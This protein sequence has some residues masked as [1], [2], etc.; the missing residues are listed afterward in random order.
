VTSSRRRRELARARYER[1]V[2]RREAQ[3]QRARRRQAVIGSVL[4]VALVIGGVFAL[5]S[6]LRDGDT[7]TPAADAPDPSPAATTSAP[8]QQP[9]RYTASGTPARDVGV[10]RFDAKAAAEPYTATIRTNRGPVTLE[11]RSADAPCA[12][13][14][15]RYLAEK[16]FFDKTPCPRLAN[17]G[18]LAILQCG[19]PTGT[20]TGGPGYAFP[21]EN[22]E[23]ATYPAGTV[24]MAN[25]G[26]N[27]NGSQFFLVF[28]DSQLGPSYTPFGTITGGLDVLTTVAA[29]GDDGSNPAGGGK[30]KAP[31]TIEQ[32]TVAV[33]R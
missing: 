2:A 33:R 12:A 23:G 13:Y 20:T 11:A 26:P 18:T 8:A 10:P 16:K 5:A 9:C 14:S 1:Q 6:T 17:T 24:A 7:D 31:V 19:D 29:A 28:K 21:D 4:A 32:V 25:S 22:L 30:P 3:R 15:F 27:T